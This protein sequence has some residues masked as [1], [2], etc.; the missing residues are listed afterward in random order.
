MSKR[1]GKGL[2]ALFPALEIDDNDK[3]IQ[4]KLSELR[5]NP[6]QPRKDFN[7][8]AIAELTQSIKEHGVIQPIIVRKSLK[9][10]E[11]VAGER[12]F[13]ASK[14]AGLET[15]PAVVKNF[16]ESQVMEIA[17]IEN[18]QRENLNAME[19]AYAYKKLM[20]KFNLTQDEL[21]LKVGKSRPHV[22]NFLRLLQLPDNVQTYVSR[23]TLSM[24]HARALLGCKD[25]KSIVKLAKKCIDEQLSVRQLEQL[26][27]QLND[28]SRET[29]KKK[30]KQETNRVILQYEEQLKSK[31]GT[32]VKIKR[33]DKKGK[34]E[35][36]FFSD[37]DLE[38]LV[39][40]MG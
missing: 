38:R 16:T 32:S 36:E 30:V 12:R 20:D 3:V 33:G 9:G 14:E 1:L 19:V 22:A 39:D 11:I 4:I 34:I 15:I 10:Y 35:I 21:A 24:G 29:K 31:L 40:I 8:E 5:P 26:I 23:G 6:Y 27:K 7:A 25:K 13:R 18:L 37:E 28:V 2:D 17:L